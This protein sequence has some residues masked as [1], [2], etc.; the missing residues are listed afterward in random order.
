MPR[1][2]KRSSLLA[3]SRKVTAQQGSWHRENK[4]GACRAA[5][6]SFN[7]SLLASSLSPRV[8]RGGRGRHCQAL[9][10]PQPCKRGACWGSLSPH[11]TP[12]C[13]HAS[14]PFSLHKAGETSHK[15]IS[16]LYCASVHFLPVKPFQNLKDLTRDRRTSFQV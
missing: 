2:G 8:P 7:A 1:G 14:T 16:H 12:A 4:C 11:S 9:C 6:S 3:A 13:R 10:N 15:I 5:C